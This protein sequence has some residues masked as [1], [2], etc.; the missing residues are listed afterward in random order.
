MDEFVWVAL[1]Y[2]AFTFLFVGS[3][4]RFAISQETWTTK[5]SQFLEKKKLRIAGPL[6][7]FALILVFLGHVGGILVPQEV[8]ELFGITEH[9][10]HQGALYI[11]GLAGVLLVVGFALLMWRRS[12]SSYLKVNTSLM[13]VWIFLFL[14]MTILT[15]FMG[16]MMNADGAFNYR[17]YIGPWFRGL[18]ML[19]PQ[20]ELML[21]IPLIFKVHMISWMIVAILFPFSRLV[22]CLSFPFV[23]LWRSPIVYRKR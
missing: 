17:L 19:H 3:A 9:L 10:Y 12:T 13:D 23:Y 22:H 4:V 21:H 2:I 7:H 14:G 1:P 11:G 18:L 5:S 16:T 15:G 6:F 8:T 20:P